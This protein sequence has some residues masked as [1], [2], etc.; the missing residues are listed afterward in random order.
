MS[1]T[2]PPVAPTPPPAAV[3]ENSWRT[4]FIVLVT[5]LVTVVLTFVAVRYY[6]FPSSF[7]P[8]SLNPAES[9]A[10]EAKFARLEQLTGVAAPIPLRP[11]GTSVSEPPVAEPY[12]EDAERRTLR[13]TQ[14]ELNALIARNPDLSGRLAIHLAPGQM[15]VRARIPLDPDFPVFGGQTLRVASGLGLEYTAG[16]P[17]VVLRGVSLMGV[18]LPGAWLGGLKNLDLVATFGGEPGFWKALA[19]GVESLR[20]EDG[21]LV[22]VLRE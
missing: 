3:P 11:P 7:T 12:R 16:K 6:L 1:D 21:E 10:L 8:V 9:R 4:A 17:V 20:V 2:P 18:P 15:S 13:F 5:V 19:D 22:I 14:R